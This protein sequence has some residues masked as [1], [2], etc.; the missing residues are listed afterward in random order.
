MVFDRDTRRFPAGASRRLGSGLIAAV[1]ALA[2]LAV[3]GAGHAMRLEL[4]FV[5][6]AKRRRESA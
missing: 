6:R 2:V 4:R 3:A 5:S 1:G